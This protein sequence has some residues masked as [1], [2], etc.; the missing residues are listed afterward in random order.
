VLLETATAVGVSSGD[1]IIKVTADTTNLKLY[2]DGVLQDTQ[3]LGASSVV[4]NGNPWILMSNAT[5][6]CHYYKHTV[7]GL[8]VAYYA[9][10]DIIRGVVYSTGTVTVTNGDAT[11]T[12]AGGATWTSAMDGCL[13]VSADAVQ[14]VISSVTSGTTLELTVVYGGGTLGGQTY[15]M[16]VRLPD[17]QGTVH[18]GRITWGA[19]PA[20]VTASLGGL[21]SGSQPAPGISTEDNTPRDLM[22]EVPVSDWYIDPA[23]S[24]TLQTNPIRPLVQVL[25]DN[26]P[27]TEIEGWRVLGGAFIMMVFALAAKFLHGH[28]LLVGISTAT[29][30]GATIAMTIFPLIFLI[31]VII[32]ILA[33]IVAER[34]QSV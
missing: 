27:M 28:Y 32:C 2:V 3:A 26:T 31:G 6:Y 5:P 17:R 22:P 12:G 4:N 33:G 23:V 24:T 30:I 10:N 11:V 34:M 25:S 19:N 20:G 18:D 8:L 14:Y 15:N 1:H 29:A 7:G 21:V 9:P 13:F 16:Y